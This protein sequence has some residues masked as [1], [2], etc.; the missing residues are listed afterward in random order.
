MNT[1]DYKRVA[2]LILDG[3]AQAYGEGMALSRDDQPTEMVRRLY[4]EH[5]PFHLNFHEWIPH[6]KEAAE[7]WYT[8]VAPQHGPDLSNITGYKIE[9]V[10]YSPL[11]VTSLHNYDDKHRIYCRDCDWE[12]TV[13]E[14]P[15]DAGRVMPDMCP[16][17]AKDNELSFVD[18]DPVEG[19]EHVRIN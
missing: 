17:C 7:D 9:G 6:Q 5:G 1:E 16:D 11:K 19:A 10:L 14:L 3:Q 18:K 12:T 13:G 8:P 4:R 2:Q 15:K